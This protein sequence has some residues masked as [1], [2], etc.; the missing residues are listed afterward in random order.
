MNIWRLTVLAVAAA[1]ITGCATQPVRTTLPAAPS[2]QHRD[3]LVLDNGEELIGE[4]VAISADT[5]R[6][7]PADA[8]PGEW[9]KSQI[10]RIDLG[11]SR[12]G[13]DWRGAVDI[14]DPELSA[15]LNALPTLE[16]YPDAGYVD[17]LRSAR[18]TMDADGSTTRTYRVIRHILRERGRDG[19]L[20]RFA[21]FAGERAR[22]DHARTVTQTG[23]V[24]P[25]TDAAIEDAA[26]NARYPSH[27]RLRQTKFAMRS[28]DEG[29]TLD[30]QYT[31]ISPPPTLVRPFWWQNVL[32]SDQPCQRHI[33]QLQ[34]PTGALTLHIE[35]AAG[36]LQIEQSNDGDVV[37]VNCSATNLP[38]ITWENYRPPSDR[39]SPVVTAA[40]ADE[41]AALSGEYAALLH[42]LAP[43][44]DSFIDGFASAEPNWEHARRAA[45]EIA[46]KFSRVPVSIREHGY[47]P[48]SPQETARTLRG[49]DLD[50]AVLLWHVLEQ[51][52]HSAHLVLAATRDF[53]R[54]QQAVPS[55]GYFGRAGVRLRDGSGDH[56][57]FL[58]GDTRRPDVL[59]AS[60]QGATTL[61]I[62]D[63]SLST[64]PFLDLD[65]IQQSSEFSVRLHADGSIAG[66]CRFQPGESEPR[67]RI[68][69]DLPDDQR[70]LRI[71]ELLSS[72]EPRAVLSGYTTSDLKDL[73]QP[74][75]VE[76][77]FT[78]PSYIIPAGSDYL[79]VTFPGTN[80]RMGGVGIEDRKYPMFWDSPLSASVVSEISF[81]DSLRLQH[82]PANR[83]VSNEIAR[84]RSVVS[85][86]DRVARLEMTYDRFAVE[87]PASAFHDFQRAVEARNAVSDD[88]IVLEKLH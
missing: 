86:G 72:L 17:I 4:L 81:P 25:L 63:D 35:D 18:V 31:V 51:T 73:L 21:Y 74:V 58:E 6:F 68:M 40:S 23:A 28:G 61:V 42:D 32:L 57:L 66:T 79:L 15:A 80:V 19:A 48:Q 29:S 3:I 33:T 65:E 84:L 22:I 20:I 13:D 45:V 10:E 7:D 12:P 56:F 60:V 71:Q 53:S 14:T 16:A 24:L 36:L 8:A 26:V 50:L 82:L 76:M 88:V 83:D 30:I 52:G 54:V 46:Q 11:L 37:T 1:L 38:G 27:D 77:S 75:E 59:S 70:K 62:G 43:A 39:L 2:V 47:L 41:W 5:V 34:F 55:L 78:V 49:N 69:K 67:I 9:P 85:G 44:P 64:L 87:A